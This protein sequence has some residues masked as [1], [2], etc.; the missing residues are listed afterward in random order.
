MGTK[1]YDYIIADKYIIPTEHS[2][3]YSEKIIY[4]PETYQ[5][6]TPKEF[7]INIKRSDYDLPEKKFILGSF[8]RI[9]KILPNIFDTWMKILKSMTMLIW[10]YV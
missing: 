7:N 2:D 5:P 8:S 6:H 9:E 4:M 3:F 10:L 1:K